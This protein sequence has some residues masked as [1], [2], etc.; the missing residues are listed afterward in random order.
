MQ[1]PTRLPAAKGPPDS[2]T[3]HD[4]AAAASMIS[5]LMA[6]ARGLATSSPGPSTG[7]PTDSAAS[8]I[9]GAERMPDPPRL[10]ERQ[11][12]LAELA[13]A[14]ISAPDQKFPVRPPGFPIESLIIDRQQGIAAYQKALA[15]NTAANPPLLLSGDGANSTPV[16]A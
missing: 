14:L 10:V 1:G 15:L 9:P 16:S 8:A 13:T 11:G 5:E 12:T 3:T 7:P 4:Q 6:E 2:A